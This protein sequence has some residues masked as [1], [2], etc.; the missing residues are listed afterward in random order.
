MIGMVL[1]A[2]ASRRLRPETDHLPKP[3]RRADV[4]PRRP[5]Q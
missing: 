1:A 4:P 2:G 3:R 5:E